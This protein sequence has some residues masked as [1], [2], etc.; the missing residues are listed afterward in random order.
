MSSRSLSS[1]DMTAEMGFRRATIQAPVRR[2]TMMTSG[3]SSP[4]R[5]NASARTSR[6]SAS[7]LRTQL[8]GPVVVRTSP[9][10]AAVPLGMFLCAC[11]VAGDAC[12]QTSRAIAAVAAMTAAAP[13]MSHFIVS[14]AVGGL[15]DNPPE[16]KVMPY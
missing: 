5:T 6:P 14:I 7:V 1:L 8:R 12:R 13:P 9:G 16:S 11:R 4:A 10:V 15:S 2:D 3:W